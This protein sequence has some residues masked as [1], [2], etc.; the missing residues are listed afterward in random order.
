MP[1]SE[2]PTLVKNLVIGQFLFGVGGN[3]LPLAQDTGPVETLCDGDA[4]A[5]DTAAFR[6]PHHHVQTF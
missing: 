3:D 6:V 1:L 5:L 2:I 4:A